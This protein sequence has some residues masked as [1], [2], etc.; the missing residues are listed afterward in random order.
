L[1]LAKIDDESIK[2]LDF[3]KRGGL[4]PVVVQDVTT[5]DILMLAYEQ[6]LMMN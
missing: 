3:V 6:K 5:K 1:L 2:K 4:I